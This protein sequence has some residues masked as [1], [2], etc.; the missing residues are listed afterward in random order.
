MKPSHERPVPAYAVILGLTMGCGLGLTMGCGPGEPRTDAEKLTRGKEIVER[1]SNK[2]AS[3]QA[4]TMTTHET[5]ERI[6]SGGQVEVVK[7]A[8][9]V[10]IKR[11][12]R[13]Y[14]KASGD[15]D[16]E[17][18][19][20]GVGLTIVL[21]KEKVFGQARMPET[22]DKTLD[23]M[24]ERY[25]I[26]TPI[27]DFTRSSP[28]KALIADTTTGGWVG[29]E[30]QDG[31]AC[32]HL[33]FKDQGVAWELWVPTQGDPLP[34]RFSAQFEG[35]K[36]LRK[37]DATFSNWNLSPTIAADRFDPHVPPDYE[38]IAMVQRARVLKNVKE[39]QPVGDQGQKK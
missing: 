7:T 4:V 9:D 11:P 12:D 34:K 26:I 23:A 13:A 24:Q 32:D 31:V 28:A 8:R 35:Y 38:G 1:M 10:T 19:Y 36:R 27:A 3:A 20:D 37:I 14:Y 18:F 17:A 16:S 6:K 21:H 22:L 39:D 25:G 33:A 29:R 15:V 5:R 2:L 30:N